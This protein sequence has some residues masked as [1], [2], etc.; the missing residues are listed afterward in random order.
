MAI[1]LR[2][3]TSDNAA[4]KRYALEKEK[5][6]VF[7]MIQRGGQ[8]VIE[9]LPEFLQQTIKPIITGTIAEPRSQ[10]TTEAYGQK[11][12]WPSATHYH[13][14]GMTRTYLLIR[15]LS[16]LVFNALAISVSTGLESAS[17]SETP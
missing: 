13:N 1:K 11:A 17:A 16:L 9:L 4:R 8:V 14:T 10:Q 3:L 15:F 5:P 6:L 2:T 12:L 7:S